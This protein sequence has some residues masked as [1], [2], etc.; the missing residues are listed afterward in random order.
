MRGS[1]TS[2]P[3]WPGRLRRRRRVLG[4]AGRWRR[5]AAVGV[6]VLDRAVDRVGRRGDEAV[7]VGVDEVLVD[8]AGLVAG[9]ALGLDLLGGDDVVLRDAADG[10]AVDV[11]LGREAVEVL[12]ADALG[13][14]VGEDV[15]V[16][17][18]DVRHRPGVGL[19]LVRR[20]RSELPVVVLVL[21]V[22]EAEGAAGGV[23]VALD[24]TSLPSRSR[25]GFTE[26][27]SRTAGQATPTRMLDRI[28][29]T[30]AIAG[31]CRLR[32]KAPAKNAIA[33]ITE[34][35]SRISL[36]GRTAFRSV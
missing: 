8:P 1:L 36:A 6:G 24:R 11:Q 26:N 23:H 21:D 34:M 18:P 16:E 3:G 2:M 31:S 30:R 4:V 5:V 20:W 13:E 29:S 27:W 15:R 14:G 32:R 19:D 33:Q 28:S 12:A 35:H 7:A 25:C 10:V 22:G 9:Q 17:Q